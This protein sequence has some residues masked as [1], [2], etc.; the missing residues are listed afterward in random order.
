MEYIV[1]ENAITGCQEL[2]STAGVESAT[3]GCV[4]KSTDAYV[5]ITDC[6]DC[7]L[8]MVNGSATQLGYNASASNSSTAIGLNAAS[9][10]AST[11]IGNGACAIGDNEIHIKGGSAEVISKCNCINISNG[12]STVIDVSDTALNA[13]SEA[14]IYLN[15]ACGCIDIKGCS[16]VAVIDASAVIVGNSATGLSCSVSIGA[17]VTTAACS[18]AIGYC[19]CATNGSVALGYNATAT[20]GIDIKSPNAEVCISN[21]QIMIGHCVNSTDECGF[22]AGNNINVC[23]DLYNTVVGSSISLGCSTS[24]SFNVILGYGHEIINNDLVGLTVVGSSI[25]EC[26]IDF[27]G[28]INDGDVILG[29]ADCAFQL[30]ASNGYLYSAGGSCL[31]TGRVLASC[32]ELPATNCSLLLYY[33]P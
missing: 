9:C 31:M 19:A 24:G 32:S 10:C 5:C 28:G 27:K 16:A 33:V 21:N 3:I 11:A 14:N 13:C 23:A 30:C 22:I 17:N 15:V 2:V 20:C 12:G 8:G 4:W 29:T 1:L 6:N 26:G 25:D 7:A 18:T